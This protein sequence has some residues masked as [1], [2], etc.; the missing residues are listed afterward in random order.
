MMGCNCG[1]SK[2]QTRQTAAQTKTV[3]RS[4]KVQAARAA[5]VARLAELKGKK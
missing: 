1:K 4:A 3:S 2:T 5:Y